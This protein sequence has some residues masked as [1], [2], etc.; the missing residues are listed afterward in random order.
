MKVTYNTRRVSCKHVEWSLDKPHIFKL[1]G[2]W[3]LYEASV[4]GKSSFDK[5]KINNH[6]HLARI[7][8]YYLNQMGI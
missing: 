2:K 1:A 7:F 3:C 4:S 5:L 8:K 6:N